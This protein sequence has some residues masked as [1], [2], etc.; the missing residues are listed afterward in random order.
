MIAAVSPSS[1][2][3]VG[4]EDE[5]GDGRADVRDHVEQ[6][7]DHAQ[8]DGVA[9]SE[10]PGRHALRRPGDRR[11]HD[12]ADRPARD[13]LRHALP[14]LEPALVLARHEHARQRAL[15][16]PDVAEQE[17]AD[18]EDREAGEED[19]EEAARDPE[20]APRSRPGSRREICSAPSCTFPRRAG[21]AEPR[22]ARPTSRSCSTS[23]GRSW[24]KS[25][26]AADERHEQ[27]QQEHE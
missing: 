8:G 20:H 27:Q 12:D 23:A 4:H 16:V 25:R 26:D 19:A 24:R 21:V 6:T 17:E 1:A 3:S 13:R 9:R 7:R 2:H 10:D 18:E 15:E 5:A 22:R 14:D 11:D